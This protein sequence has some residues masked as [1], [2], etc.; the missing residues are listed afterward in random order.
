[1]APEFQRDAI[2]QQEDGSGGRPE[3][4]LQLAS[5]LVPGH[6]PKRVT[7]SGIRKSPLG[8]PGWSAAGSQ[9]TRRRDVNDASSRGTT[10]PSLGRGGGLLLAAVV[11]VAGLGWLSV[12]GRLAGIQYANV[13]IVHPYPPPG[14]FVNPFTG[15]PRD[16][17]SSAEAGKPIDGGVVEVPQPLVAQLPARV[18]VKGKTSRRDREKTRRKDRQNPAFVEGDPASAPAPRRG[19][20]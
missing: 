10:G 1:M 11:I 12:S 8:E 5:D 7:R 16:L 3:D 4:A 15:D 6:S 9:R 13:P 18:N 20:A 19:S 14:Q 17:V 2:P